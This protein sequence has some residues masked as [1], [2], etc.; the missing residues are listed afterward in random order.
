[1]AGGESEER[2]AHSGN[3]LV[4]QDIEG[5]GDELQFCPFRKTNGTRYPR[6]QRDDG[7]HVESIASKAGRPLI[8]AVAV[9]IEIGVDQRRIRLAA[10]R[11]ENSGQLPAFGQSLEDPVV[12]ALGIIQFP[13]C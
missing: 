12:D 5:F 11:V 10:L 9:A 2:G 8:A 7:R 3:V 6:V 4:V 1:M 13:R